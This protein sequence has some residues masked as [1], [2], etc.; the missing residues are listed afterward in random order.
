MRQVEIITH[1]NSRKVQE[2]VNEFLKKGYEVI[3]IK[4]HVTERDF[5]VMLIYETKNDHNTYK[6]SLGQQ[7]IV[8][9]EFQSP[10]GI[11]FGEKRPDL[12]TID[13][14]SSFN[15][16]DFGGLIEWLSDLQTALN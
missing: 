11:R 10:R 14:H 3:E 7:S 5:T 13:C 8:L 9:K 1:P 2:F 12:I 6:L 4:S 15:K 16:K